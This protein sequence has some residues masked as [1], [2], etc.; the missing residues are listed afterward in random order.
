LFLIVGGNSEIGAAAANLIRGH[1]NEVLATTRRSSAPSGELRLDFGS[2]FDELVIP[3]GVTS[4]C[5]CVAVARLAAC[6]ADPAGSAH[7]NVT[8]TLKLVDALL[9]RGIHTLFLSS[10]QVFDGNTPHV[11]ADA[12]H[13]PVS[14]YG[15][16]K[17]RVE[18]LL[19]ERMAEGAPLAI[20]RLSKVVSPGMALIR[21]W[22]DDLRAGRPIRAFYDMTLA[23][24]P[25]DLVATAIMRMMLDRLRATVQISGPRDATYVDVAR[26]LAGRLGADQNLIS[27]VSALESGMPAGAVPRHTTLDSSVVGR[28]YGLV[29]P[30][31]FGVIGRL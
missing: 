26:F 21:N 25:V 30:D 14:E 17:A 12:R 7:V 18:S 28:R 15:R 27:P 8:R 24:V 23:P 1:G 31:P 22:I 16:Q 29:V 6:Q 19:R 3:S 2:S 5:I 20:L 13:S 4:A 11:P 10:N 9:K